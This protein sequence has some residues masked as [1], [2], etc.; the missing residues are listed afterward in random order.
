MEQLEPTGGNPPQQHRDA[1]ALHVRLELIAHLPR[2]GDVVEGHMLTRCISR[3]IRAPIELE[4]SRR[5]G[6]LTWFGGAAARASSTARRSGS[7]RLGLE[8][9]G[10]WRWRAQCQ[11][12][13]PGSVDEMKI[14][15]T[16]ERLV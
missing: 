6:Q 8:Q 11:W 9:S 3:P 14:T 7:G 12:Q 15:T 4:P 5:V 13:W 10:D 16:N 1:R 2:A